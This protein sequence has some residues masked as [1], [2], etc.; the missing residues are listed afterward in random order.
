MKERCVVIIL[1]EKYGWELEIKHV[2]TPF[3][4]DAI[5]MSVEYGFLIPDKKE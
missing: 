2:F 3:V 4:K 1:N 5:Y